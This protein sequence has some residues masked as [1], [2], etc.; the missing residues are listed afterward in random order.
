MH[1]HCIQNISPKWQDVDLTGRIAALANNKVLALYDL[2][3]VNRVSLRDNAY[4]YTSV[5]VDFISLIAKQ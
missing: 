2:D 5:E 3:R 4:M 1:V